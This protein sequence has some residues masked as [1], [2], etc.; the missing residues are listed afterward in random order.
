MARP[1]LLLRRWVA[2]VWWLGVAVALAGLAL[3]AAHPQRVGPEQPLPFSHRLH[4]G[5]KGISC[6]F[7]HP[8]ADRSS[9]AGLPEVGKCM[10]CHR[11]IA[12][13][14]APIKRLR[15]YYDTGT[16]IPWVRVYRL[17]DYVFFNHAAHLRR[18]VDCAVCHGNVQG[19]DRV[20][21]NQKLTMGFCVDCHRRPEYQ[22]SV[23]CWRCHR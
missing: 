1:P 21:L 19:M 5:D 6:Y 4:A 3:L 15:Q 9:V 11:V 18:G 7:C 12:P 13:D 17:S 14:F 20:A 22:A 10:V 23:D 2:R 16:P 8:G